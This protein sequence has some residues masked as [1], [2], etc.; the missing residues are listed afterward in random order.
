MTP[1]VIRRSG[2]MLEVNPACQEFLGPELKYDHLKLNFTPFGSYSGIAKKRKDMELISRMLYRLDGGKLYTTQGAL[3]RIQDTLTRYKI[4]HTFEDLRTNKTLVPDYENLMRVMPDL[5]FRYKQ[6]EVLARLVGLDSGVI[7]APTAYGKTFIMLMLIA[8][9]PKANIIIATPGVP[10][11]E[12]TRR[13]IQEKVTLQVGTVGGGQDCPDRVTLV[14]Y[15]SLRKAPIA[16]CDI[17]LI[18][19]C[20]MV[21][22]SQTALDLSVISNPVKIFGLTATPRGRSDNAELVMEALIGPVIYT[23]EYQ[24]AAQAGMVSKIDV[25]CL[26]MRD[27]PL[28]NTWKLR[29]ARKRNLYWKNTWRN[30]AFAR[31]ILQEIASRGDPQVLV[32]TETLEHAFRMAHALN[33]QHGSYAGFAVVYASMSPARKD[34]FV[35]AGLIPESYVPLGPKQRRELLRDFESGKLRRVIAT[36][37][38]GTGVDFIHLD[39]VANP[40]GMSSAITS[41]QWAG[42][43]SRTHEGKASGILIDSRDRW[44]TWTSRRAAERIKEYLKKGWTVV[45]EEC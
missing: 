42:R 45:E 2:N 9:Y 3:Q 24:E 39:V 1:V 22:A 32:L 15:K 31:R 33:D 37:T 14:T 29:V 17:L 28:I 35:A 12:S 19:E 10:L 6:D 20:H 16:K 44:D 38:W 8:L 43:N 7:V 40:S 30:Q 36:G 4:E 5:I 21:P 13:R 27:C 25:K 26:S 34:E 18:D 23:V 41:I 11:L